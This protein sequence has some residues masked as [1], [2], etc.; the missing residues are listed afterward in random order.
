MARETLAVALELVFGDEAGL[1]HSL[2]GAFL[3]QE[4]AQGGLRCVQPNAPK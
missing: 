3:C 1:Q 4:R 2:T